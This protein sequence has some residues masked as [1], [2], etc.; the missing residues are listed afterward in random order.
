MATTFR[1]GQCL[2]ISEWDD[3]TSLVEVVDCNAAAGVVVIEYLD[4]HRV[5]AMSAAA[6]AAQVVSIIGYCSMN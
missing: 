1:H 3:T 4:D 5:M 6:L 2:T